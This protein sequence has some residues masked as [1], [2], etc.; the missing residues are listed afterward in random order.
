MSDTPTPG[1]R[2]GF[3]LA[4]AILA[5]VAVGALVTAGFFAASQ[6]GRAALSTY[7][8]TEAFHLAEQGLNTVLGTWTRANFEQLDTGQVVSALEETVS[9]GGDRAVGAYSVH[10]RRMGPRLFFVQSEGRLLRPDGQPGAV[11]RI[12]QT[13]R[14]VSFDVPPD[15]AMQVFGG[16]DVRGNS[17][18][19]GDDF[20]P[21]NWADCD[22]DGEKAAVVAK[23]TSRIQRSGAAK[24]EGDP[25]K[26]EDPDLD[27]SDFLEYGDLDFDALFAL[28]EKLYPHGTTVTNTAPV[29]AADGSCD[30]SPISNWGAPLDTAHACHE[31]F[32]IIGGEGDLHFASS[33]SGQGILLVQGDLR[34][35]G[36]FEFYGIVVVRGKFTTAGTGGKINGIVM[37]Y[38]GGD[39]DTDNLSAG[40]TVVNYSSC[41]IQRAQNYNEYTSRAVPITRRSWIDLSAAGVS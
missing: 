37:V 41:P 22:Y 21:N 18:I 10:V 16:L 27:H 23:D 28:A 33:S 20:I 2:E 34:I 11:R 26:L 3:A 24:I 40:N 19:R 39:L 38:S 31:Y 35:T 13:V 17:R 9:R 7:H 8:G 29:L 5:V 1:N 36:G 12:G 25:P 30:R 14:I 32:P 6:E 4:A 15:R